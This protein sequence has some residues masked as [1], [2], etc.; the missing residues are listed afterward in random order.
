MLLLAVLVT[1]TAAERRALKK[2][3]DGTRTAWRDR[4]RADRA[5]RRDGTLQRADRP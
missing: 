3:I 1:L 4:L 5:G 2:R